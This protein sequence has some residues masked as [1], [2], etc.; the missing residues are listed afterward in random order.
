MLPNA[1][2]CPECPE[3]AKLHME[4]LDDVILLAVFLLPAGPQGHPEKFLPLRPVV[5]IEGCH[6]LEKVSF[7]VI[8]SQE[9]AQS[10]FAKAL[11]VSSYLRAPRVD[12]S[13]YPAILICHP[14][15]ASL[16]CLELKSVEASQSSLKIIYSRSWLDQ[17]FVGLNDTVA[18]TPF[19]F[20][21]VPKWDGTVYSYEQENAPCDQG[22]YVLRA[23]IPSK[24]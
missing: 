5:V 17:I 22:G 18:E 14:R 11:S 15:E 1:P 8:N 23:K 3:L 19:L 21:V 10:I 13:C 2:E 24:R 12:Y 7:F 9:Q 20:V 4:T 6:T 16:T